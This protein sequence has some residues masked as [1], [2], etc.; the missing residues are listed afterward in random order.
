VPMIRS[1]DVD[2]IDQKQVVKSNGPVGV[3]WRLLF[4]RWWRGLGGASRVVS[5][6]THV[7]GLGFSEDHGVDECVVCFIGVSVVLHSRVT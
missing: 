4:G 2:A 1:Q 5:T 3:R 6:A 7:V